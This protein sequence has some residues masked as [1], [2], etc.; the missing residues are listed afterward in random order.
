MSRRFSAWDLKPGTGVLRAVMTQAG[1]RGTGGQGLRTHH[2]W[3]QGHEPTGG[4]VTHLCACVRVCVCVRRSAKARAS[5]KL[6]ESSL[7]PGS[8]RGAHCAQRMGSSSNQA[9]V[10]R[11]ADRGA[12]EARPSRAVGKSR[13][14]QRGDS[15]GRARNPRG[16]PRRLR[17]RD[18]VTGEGEGR[19]TSEE[20]AGSENREKAGA[21]VGGPWLPGVSPKRLESTSSSVPGVVRLPRLMPSRLLKSESLRWCRR[22][23]GREG[24]GSGRGTRCPEKL[25]QGPLTDRGCCCELMRWWRRL[26]S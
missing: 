26:S 14:P 19:A 4:R 8:E 12:G 7:R 17:V 3:A 23:V 22:Q 13:T 18:Q 20:P 1:S 2:V 24:S 16:V 6:L 5:P 25:Q 10:K 9:W 21:A 15:P 11:V